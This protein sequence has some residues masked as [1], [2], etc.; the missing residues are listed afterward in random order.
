MRPA[1]A[2]ADEEAITAARDT[3]AN[4]NTDRPGAALTVGGA[5]PWV[6]TGT[7]AG[8][9][10]TRLPR[11]TAAGRTS[12]TRYEVPRRRRWPAD[13][14]GTRALRGVARTVP[15][16]RAGKVVVAPLSAGGVSPTRVRRDGRS[17]SSVEQR[18]PEPRDQHFEEPA[19]GSIPRQCFAQFVEAFASHPRASYSG[20]ILRPA[21]EVCGQEW[22]RS[23]WGVAYPLAPAHATVSR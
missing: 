19:S 16:R 12:R 18:A 3:Q 15:R 14:A 8:A 5:A 9:V 10:D 6:H 7:D 4:R 23:P 21:S 1:R 20:H 2:P 17:P 13:E 22:V 11:R